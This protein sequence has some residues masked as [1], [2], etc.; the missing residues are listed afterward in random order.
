M[1]LHVKPEIGVGITE[2]DSYMDL[3]DRA[4]AACNTAVQLAEHGLEIDPT[5]EDQDNAAK[6]VAAYAEDPEGTSKQ[7]TPKRASTLTP[8]SLVLT[9]AILKEFGQ[10]VVESSLHIRHLVTNKLLLESENDDARIRMRALE[11]LG[12][13]SDVGLFSEKSEITITHQSTDDLRAKLKG[14]LEKLVSGEVIEDGVFIDVHAEL[15]ITEE[16]TVEQKEYDD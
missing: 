15:G 14:K 11:L 6:L 9:D 1:V 3:K 12:K 10:S 2:S 7:V 5:L 16:E 13:I 8:A 4:E